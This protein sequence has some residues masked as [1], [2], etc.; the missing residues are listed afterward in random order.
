MNN[1]NPET[2]DKH[3]ALDNINPVKP[4]KR[5]NKETETLVRVSQKQITVNQCEALIREH[6]IRVYNYLFHL[7]GDTH[8]AEDLCQETFIK[9]WL[10]LKQFRGCSQLKTWIFSIARNTFLDETRKG[11]LTEVALDETAI[12]IADMDPSVNEKLQKE[13]RTQMLYD[14]IQEFSE[15]ERTAILLHYREELSFRQLGNVMKVPT[16]TAK[17]YVSKGLAGLREILMSEGSEH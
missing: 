16:G 14:A 11:R 8:L 7:C 12:E 15:P 17:Y 3:P 2:H 1:S 5:S 4:A 6:Y 9:I 13:E 10:H